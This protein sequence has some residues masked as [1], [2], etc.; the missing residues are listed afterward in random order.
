MY[1]LD[2]SEEQQAVV[3]TLSAYLTDKLPVERHRMDRGGIAQHEFSSWSELA[4]MGSFN[5]SAGEDEGGAG[6]T[7]VEEVLA[8]REFGR[9]LLSPCVLATVLAARAYGRLGETEK[10]DALLAGR[11]RAAFA[12]P[13]PRL[14]VESDDYLLF[15]GDG[16]D[17][18]VVWVESGL[19]LFDKD[20]LVVNGPLRGLD[21]AVT[22]HAVSIDKT[23][24][25]DWIS[26]K[27]DPISHLGSLLTAAMLAG[28]SEAVRDTAVEY[29]KLREQFGRPI[30]AFQAIKHSC[31]DMAVRSEGAWAQT[32][33][34]ALK[35]DGGAAD[36]VFHV[37]C[38]KIVATEA[39]IK[40][41]Q[42][43]IQIHGAIGFTAENNTH[44]FLKR[45]HLLSQLCGAMAT[46]SARVMAVGSVEAE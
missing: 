41:A 31:A 4:E 36:A 17:H 20:K 10:R 11:S 23:A 12:L 25:H 13:A 2:T 35:L 9:A 43:S 28:I 37:A 44:L 22:L 6:L 21:G 26:A 3:D 1:Y 32:L 39:A 7:I 34:A 5:I 14:A 27:S 46:Q 19:A 40:G 42:R 24:P 33:V 45:A 18:I 38:A 30:G 8:F 16:A 15:D 29:A